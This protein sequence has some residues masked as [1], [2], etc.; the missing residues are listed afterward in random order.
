MSMVTCG[1]CNRLID[2]DV[3]AEHFDDCDPDYEAELQNNNYEGDTDGGS[4]LDEQA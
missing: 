4:V 1:I 3:D 2:T